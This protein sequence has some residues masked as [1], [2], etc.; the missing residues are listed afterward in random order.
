LHT[1]SPSISHATSL[2]PVLL[3]EN[4][5]V[6]E[7]PEE[8]KI[9]EYIE[10]LYLYGNK[11]K[12]TLPDGISSM[13]QLRNLDI[14]RNAFGGQPLVKLYDLLKLRELHLSENQF[15]EQMSGPGIAHWELLKEFWIGSNLFRGAIPE[16]IGRMESLGIVYLLLTF[17][18]YLFSFIWSLTLSKTLV[19]Y[20]QSRYL[21]TT[22]S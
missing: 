16:E 22:T 10:D 13:K 2:N 15:D 14:E 20:I 17:V 9:L 1:S 18:G 4:N 11:L 19:L 12:G 21:S 8:I 5:L 6:G 7:L 3:V